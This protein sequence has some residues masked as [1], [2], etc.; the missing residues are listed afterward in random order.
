MKNKPIII[1]A[2]EPYS[3][4]SEIFFKVYKLNFIKKYNYPIILVG[5]K[6]LIETQMKKL[7]FFFK[8]NIIK[9]NEL[10]KISFNNNKI[11]LIDVKLNFKKPFRKISTKSSNYIKKCFNIGLDIMNDK[12][13]SKMIILQILNI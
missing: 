9:K 12:K 3:V 6:K 5:S 13:N 8:L 11:N 7:K 4:F 10:S 1:V 2:G